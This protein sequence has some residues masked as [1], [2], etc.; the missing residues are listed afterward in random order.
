MIDFLYNNIQ[1]IFSGV[2]LPIVGWICL[3][4]K[5]TKKEDINDTKYNQQGGDNSVNIQGC[6]VEIN[7]FKN[8]GDK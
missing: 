6:N 2:G 8:K 4:W 3:K 5:K 1:W 7:D